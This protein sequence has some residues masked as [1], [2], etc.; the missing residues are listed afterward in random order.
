MKTIFITGASS[1]LGKETAKLFQK[2]GWQVIATMRNP[3]KE[4]ELSVLENVSIHQLDITETENMDSLV[5]ELTAN[6]K[7]DLVLNNAGYGLIGP[8]EG[9]SQ[10]Q[11]V[12]LDQY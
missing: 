7:I 5:K 1:G 4:Q 3:E 12:K 9:L 11:I 2:N 8:L 6:Y 10:T